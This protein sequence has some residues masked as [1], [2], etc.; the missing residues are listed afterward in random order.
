MNF[1]HEKGDTLPHDLRT[2]RSETTGDQLV[3]PIPGVGVCHT[4]RRLTPF[5]VCDV[6][7]SCASPSASGNVGASLSLTVALVL[8]KIFVYS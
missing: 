8:Y 6:Q 5:S 1:F 2:K 7:I 3:P 4:G